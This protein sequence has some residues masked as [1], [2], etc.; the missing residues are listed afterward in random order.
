MTPEVFPE[1]CE[2]KCERC[3]AH[4]HY[5]KHEALN[6]PFCGIGFTSVEFSF[7]KQLAFLDGPTWKEYCRAQRA[8]DKLLPE[9]VRGII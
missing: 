6:C 7:N 4:W 2:A 1:Q 8:Q 9:R 3:G 5:R